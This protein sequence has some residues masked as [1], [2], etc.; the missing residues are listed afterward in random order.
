MILSSW[1][2][3]MSA[4]KYLGSPYSRFGWGEMRPRA[5]QQTQAMSS[6][7]NQNIGSSVAR[8]DARLASMQDLIDDR[9]RAMDKRISDSSLRLLQP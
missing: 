8:E 7:L 2:G 9:L 1:F 3:S 4:Q 5:S 6:S